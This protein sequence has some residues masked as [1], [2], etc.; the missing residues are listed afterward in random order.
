MLWFPETEDSQTYVPSD[1]NVFNSFH[2]LPVQKKT[3]GDNGYVYYL[4]CGDIITGV[5][6]CQKSSNCIH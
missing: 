6:T 5:C 1:Q 2:I 3:S 4:D